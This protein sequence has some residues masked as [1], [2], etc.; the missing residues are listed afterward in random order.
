MITQ[1]RGKNIYFLIQINIVSCL[2]ININ[3]ENLELLDKTK[4][5]KSDRL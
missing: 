2:D 1:I 3:Q 4:G 5:D